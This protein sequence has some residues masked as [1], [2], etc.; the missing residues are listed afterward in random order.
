MYTSLDRCRRRG[1]SLGWQGPIFVKYNAT[2]RRF[3][4]VWLEQ[5]H[6]NTYTTTLHCVNS[7]V[8]KT[9]QLTRAT[10]V[11]RGIAGGRLPE[12]FVTPNRYGVCGGVEASFMSTTTDKSVALQYA[13]RSDAGVVFEIQQG[14][15]DRG[16]DI[17]WCSQYPHE[18]EIVFAPLTG[19]EV[20]SARV[21]GAVIVV[22]VRLSVNMLSETIEEVVSKRFK[23]VKSMCVQMCDQMRHALA[24]DDGWSQ[25]CAEATAAPL[26]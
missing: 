1:R 9:A 17:E 26:P 13:Q 25:V 6:G 3:P 21:E 18:R 16:A 11:Y 14:M 2:L 8:V 19:L 15:V 4:L 10:K 5:C 23:V 22:A 24:T 20:Q 12:A 7:C